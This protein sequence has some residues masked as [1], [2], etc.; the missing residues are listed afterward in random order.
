[1][2][3]LTDFIRKSSSYAIPVSVTPDVKRMVNSQHVILIGTANDQKIPNVSPRS[4]FYVD[5]DVIYGYEIFMH[6]SYQNFTKSHEEKIGKLILNNNIKR[7]QFR[8]LMSYLLNS[9]DFE[10]VPGLLELDVD[11]DKPW[12]LEEFSISYYV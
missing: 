3:I 5:N 2:G 7:I 11:S 9:T 4:S 10:K 1:M 12:E 6:K 8:P